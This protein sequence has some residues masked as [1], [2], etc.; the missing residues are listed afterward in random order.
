MAKLSEEQIEQI[1]A[2]NKAGVSLRTL[3]AR[4]GVSRR[5]LSRLL[6]IEEPGY[7]VTSQPE[8]EAGTV[9]ET[10]AEIADELTPAELERLAVDPAAGVEAQ[11]AR[12]LKA[13]AE[14]EAT[15]KALTA[16]GYHDESRKHRD[17]LIRIENTLLRLNRVAPDNVI[18]LTTE[19]I[20]AKRQR[21]RERMLAAGRVRPLLCN[22]CS[23]E[24][25]AEWALGKE[26]SHE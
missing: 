23:C 20:Q 15:I 25:S 19:Q 9:D 7:P 2:D 24:L 14:E 16:G 1:R 11:R 8:H 22:T 3:E 13:V 17:A 6:A 5:T 21:A 4:Y 18:T 26:G 10:E 12:L